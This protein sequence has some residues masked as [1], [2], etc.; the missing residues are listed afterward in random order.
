[1]LS[2]DA[3]LSDLWLRCCSLLSSL[4]GNESV[5]IAVRET[6][7]DRI[8]YLFAG[9]TGGE[10]ADR[11][12]P[13]GSISNEVLA[14]GGTVV[15][16]QGDCSSV[17][18]PVAFGRTLY[19]AIC[20]DRI[21]TLDLEHIA[22]LESCALSVG[23]HL[24]HEDAMASSE[25]LARLAFTDALTGIAN[26][27]RFD[28]VFGHEWSRAIREKTVLSL[29]MI[30]LD[31]FKTFNDTYGH[32]AGDLCLQKVAH[33]LHDCIK[34]PADLVARYGG[35]E[36]VALL[37]GTDAAGATS[38]AEEMIAAVARLAISHEGSSLER[39]SLSIGAASETPSP[40]A[41]AQALLQAADYALYRA[42]LGG[43]NRIYGNDYESDA[44]IARPRRVTS[45]NNL[46]LQLSRLIGRKDD[47]TRLR[48]LLSSCRLISVVGTGGTGKTRVAIALATDAGARFSDGVWFVDLSP[49]S[50]RTLVASSIAAVFSADVP[51]D[52][53]KTDALA[54][55]LEPKDCLLVLDNC[56]HLIAEVAELTAALLRRCP[57][58]SI[59]T[60]SRESLGVAG[61]AVYRLPLLSMPAAGSEPTAS[62]AAGF[63]AVALFVERAV[64]A[65][66]SFALT[67]DNVGLVLA[68]CR[69]VDGIALA[70]ELV[71]PRVGIIGLVNVAQRLSDLG[72]LTGGDRTAPPRQRTM[73]A[74][75]AWS[76]ELLSPQERTLFCRL[77]VFAGSFTFD[78]LTQVCSGS[79]VESDEIFDLFYG[80][81][82]KSLVNGDPERDSRYRLLDSVRA[83][84]RE[85]LSES[86]DTAYF[87]LRHAQYFT[88]LARQMEA[89]PGRPSS[90]ERLENLQLDVDNFRAALE[91]TLDRRG[92]VVLGATLAAATINL[93]GF[94][95]SEA[96]R[97]IIKAL[98]VLPK[99]AAAETEAHLCIG[100]A[101]SS[102]NLPAERLRAAGE[103]AVELYRELGDNR[104]LSEALRGLAQ[105]I[106][107]YYRDERLLADSLACESIDLAREVGDSAQ[108]ALSLRMRSLTLEVDDF[109]RKRE[110]LEESLALIRDHGSDRQIAGML[111]WISEVEF[112]AGDRARALDYCREAVA[113]AQTSGSSE[114]Y[115]TVT[116]NLANYA[117]ALGDWDM[118]RSVAGETIRVARQT[119]HHQSF[120]FALQALAVRAA[121]LGQHERAARMIGFCDA[122]CGVIHPQRQANSSDLILY[123]ELV[124]ELSKRLDETTLSHAMKYGA[125]MTE[126]QAARLADGL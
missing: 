101:T 75:I 55:I 120:T 35:E 44:A 97:W 90:H 47:L 57:K 20:L 100:L 38:L 95:T 34:R 32:Q 27:R 64:E 3:P 25:R 124:A 110:V 61:E 59:L 65:N 29:L 23:A 43:R 85:E 42:K 77:A 126:E 68:I 40:S 108:L 117:C 105:I 88:A 84:A 6:E 111:T 94:M 106:G 8:A 102:R 31:Y 24:H 74:T 13:S 82:R 19:G 54:A 121:N 125:E 11:T 115:T 87:S 86:G 79:P 104:G 1:M 2:D 53:S 66:S 17:G 58:L 92:D 21:A 80:L 109:P 118:L 26:R 122:R 30:D 51:M 7:G 119:R 4:M 78:A 114:T 71:A 67:D 5:T 50:D 81:I 76:Y 41:S 93:F 14:S 103:R 70:I 63:D 107:W 33:A 52:E 22:L 49:I 91:W 123:R 116:A 69:A 15:R 113:V 62:Q 112:H 28:D 9:G 48:T 73:H 89:T 98:D 72:L 56:E 12:I 36:F 18:V 60:T 16:A 39:L 99:G 45:Q 37:P 83:F 10:P 96:T 46:P